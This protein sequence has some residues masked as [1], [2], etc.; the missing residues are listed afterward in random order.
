M[1]CSML[2]SRSLK[3][4]NSK[5]PK[6]PPKKIYTLLNPMQKSLRMK[7]SMLPSRSL[8][9]YNSKGISHNALHHSAE[10]QHPVFFFK[11]ISKLPSS[12][13]DPRVSQ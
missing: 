9:T 2:L 5:G 3:S 7:Y 4:Y 13:Q 11:E 6:K 8:K 10:Q 1:K 12:M